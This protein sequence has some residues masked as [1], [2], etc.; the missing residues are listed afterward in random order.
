MLAK[1]YFHLRPSKAV[2][3]VTIS[4]ECANKGG[5][6]AVRIEENTRTSSAEELILQEVD[7]I[8][9]IQRKMIVKKMIVEHPVN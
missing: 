1:A 6:L 9:V 2:Y 4:T 3:A 8:S 7:S 5:Q